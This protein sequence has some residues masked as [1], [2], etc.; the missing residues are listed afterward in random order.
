PAQAGHGALSPAALTCPVRVHSCYHLRL[1][2]EETVAVRGGHPES[3]HRA[4]AWPRGLLQDLLPPAGGPGHEG[5]HASLTTCRSSALIPLPGAA[6]GPSRW[7]VPADREGARLETP[8][9]GFQVQPRPLSWKCPYTSAGGGRGGKER[10]SRAWPQAWTV[11]VGGQGFGTAQGPPHRPWN[12]HFPQ[13]VTPIPSCTE[14]GAAV[15]EY[16]KREA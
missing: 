8:C 11:T 12:A 15:T 2:G 16:H 3:K 1:T 5:S 6:K 13:T 9:Q 14:S 7:W 10:S 4:K